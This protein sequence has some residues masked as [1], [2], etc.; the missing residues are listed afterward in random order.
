MLSKEVS[1]I[2]FKVFG[3]TRTG[4]EPKSP[5]LLANTKS[6]CEWS[7]AGLNT[8]T[9]ASV[10]TVSVIVI[11]LRSCLRAEKS[12][13]HESDGDTNYS[14]RTR[15]SP[16]GLEKETSGIRNQRKNQDHTDR[17]IVENS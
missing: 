6:N 2:I 12:L 17:T 5:G 13:E 11:I 8:L 10:L 15:E 3:M 14:W 7:T 1:S 9:Q 4:I 16:Q